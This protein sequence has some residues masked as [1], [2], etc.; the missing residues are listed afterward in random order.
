MLVLARRV[1]EKVYIGDDIVVQVVA[2]ASGGLRLGISAPKDK[3]IVRAELL[4]LEERGEI[5]YAAGFV[6]PANGG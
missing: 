6:D 1:G 2:G 3:R 5:E 4:R